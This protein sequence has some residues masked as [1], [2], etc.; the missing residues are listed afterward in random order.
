MKFDYL[1]CSCYHPEH[2]LRIYF[3]KEED[4]IL[5][6][7]DLCFEMYLSK[8]SFWKRLWVG[9]KYICGFKNG[10]GAYF[11]ETFLNIEQTKKL[12]NICND[13]VKL[14]NQIKKGKD[15]G[16]STRTRK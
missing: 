10:C 14:N 11:G 16:K 3:D 5:Y 15:N 7:N 2:T 9:I 13:F 12:Q 4:R 1:E 6:F 8:F